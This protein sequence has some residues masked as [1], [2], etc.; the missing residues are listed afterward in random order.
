MVFKDLRA[1]P[2]VGAWAQMKQNIPGYFGF[3]QAL[4]D[5]I[6][7]GKLEQVQHL[8]RDSRFFRALAE[9]S[10]QSL[11]KSNFLLTRHLRQ[12]ERFGHFW[13]QLQA[14]FLRTQKLLLQISGESELLAKNPVSRESI[15]IRE[16]I[17]LP[18][19]VIQQY[20]LQRLNNNNLS[21]EESEI[22]RRLVLRAM[23]GIINA[24]RNVA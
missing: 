19:I 10:M 7:Q 15:R 21:E 11:R 12:H 9:N 23:F 13:E 20:A 1:I 2:F 14:E 3:G 18:L 16:G 17:V 6:G 22:M 24:G 8:Y 4:E 5:L